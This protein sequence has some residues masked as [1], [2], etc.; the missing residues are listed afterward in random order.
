MSKKIDLVEP[1]L[2]HSGMISSITLREP[3]ARDIWQVGDLT[4]YSRTAEGGVVAVEQ[5]ERYLDYLERLL[6][7]PADKVL[8]VAGLS[9]ADAIQIEKVIDGF[10]A[11]ARQKASAPKPSSSS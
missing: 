5:N 10:F 2:G 3:K 6:I 8:V 9:A 11:D 4:T 7:E 1:I